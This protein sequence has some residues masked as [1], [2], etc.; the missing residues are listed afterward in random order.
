M[1][2][3]ITY[4]DGQNDLFDI[5]RII[6]VSPFELIPIIQKLLDSGLLREEDL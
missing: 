3:F 1:M 4:A 2:D 6:G 5:S